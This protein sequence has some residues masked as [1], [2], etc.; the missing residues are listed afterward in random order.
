MGMVAV[1]KGCFFSIFQYNNL[2]PRPN[3]LRRENL[4]LNEQTEGTIKRLARLTNGEI[5]QI[6]LNAAEAAFLSLVD[7]KVVIGANGDANALH[8][9]VGVV[10]EK[11]FLEWAQRTLANGEEFAKN[12]GSDG[13]AGTAAKFGM[14]SFAAFLKHGDAVGPEGPRRWR[15]AKHVPTVVDLK[16]GSVV[17]LLGSIGSTSG[18][19]GPI[20]EVASAAGG[21]AVAA[22]RILREQEIGR[23]HV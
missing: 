10:W 3:D 13:K 16:D 11:G 15:G 1:I 7:D 22:L 2:L 21:Q 18:A 17:D 19:Q 20:D 9:R 6:G 5:A 14:D 4:E 8:I 23:A 12:T